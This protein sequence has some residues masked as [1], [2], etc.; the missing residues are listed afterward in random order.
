METSGEAGLF[1][2]RDPF[3]LVTVRPR[4]GSPAG[5]GPAFGTFA[6]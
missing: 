3:R 5:E 1:R 2:A 6:P 4:L